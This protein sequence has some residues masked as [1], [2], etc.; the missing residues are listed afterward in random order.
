MK[1]FKMYKIIVKSLCLFILFTFF[2]FTLAT[3]HYVD[4]NAAG[5]NDGSSWQNAWN[6]LNSINWNQV[7]SGDVIY[8]STGVYYETLNIPGG[9]SGVTIRK[10]IDSGHNGT[11]V[12]DGQQSRGS[13]IIMDGSNNPI[14]SITLIGFEITG[15]TGSGIATNAESTGR[16]SNIT[17]DSLYVHDNMARGIYLNGYYNE[18]NNYNFVIKNSVFKAFAASGGGNTDGQTDLIFAGQVNN[19]LVDNNYFLQ[20]NYGPSHDDCFQGYLTSNVTL[21]NNIAIQDNDKTTETICFILEEGSGTHLFYNNVIYDITQN[22]CRD[23]KMFYKQNASGSAHTIFYGNTVYAHGGGLIDTGDPNADIQNNIFYCTGFASGYTT[24]M[25]FFNNG[26]GGGSTVDYNIYYDPTNTMNNVTGSMG[27]HDIE[28]N[29]LYKNIGNELNFDL[30]LQSGSPAIDAGVSLGYPYNTDKDGMSRPQGNGWDI[31][32]YEY[33]SGPDVTPPQLLNADILDS[34]TV[35]ANFSEALENSSA[36]NPNNYTISNGITVNSATLSGSQVTLQTTVHSNG[37]YTLTVNNVTDLS[38]NVISPSHNTADY[39]YYVEPPDSLMMLPIDTAYGDIQ[40]PL[41]TPEKTFD[42]KGSLD[43]DPDSRWAAQPMPEEITYDLGSPQ[44]IHKVKL[45]FYRYEA[46]RQY[47][48]SVSVSNDNVNWEEIVPYTMSSL[49]EWTTNSFAPVT[50][51]Y[52]KV[53]FYDNTE[54]DWAGL[55]EIQIWGIINEVTP[56]ELNTFTAFSNGNTVTLRWSTI[57]ETNNNYFEIQRSFDN[58]KFSTIGVVY[59]SGTTSN[60]HKYSYVDKNQEPVD[61]FYRLRQFDFNGN[62][63]VLNSIKVSISNQMYYELMQNYPNP[64]N[65]TTTIKFSLPKDEKVQMDIFNAL[66]QMVVKLVDKIYK[67]GIH[68]VIFMGDNL[69]SGVYFYKIQAG[70]YC[71]IRKMI[72]IK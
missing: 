49:E 7:N 54:S 48:Y 10:G 8:V 19:V 32:A 11:V 63:N 27:P 68:E 15:S 64:F 21:S 67:K 52:L 60:P 58:Q 71:K 43:G 17:M 55:W 25:V 39:V 22:N 50:R 47:H 12:I 66:G 14:D 72:L 6:S 3:N 28:A 53:H 38:G 61:R 26:R 2:S 4:K 20:N 9:T 42:G 44:E 62:Y 31:G 16:V 51:Q 13:C 70:S 59:G 30:S 29:P 23:A 1:N 34:N 65:P 46:G 40:E 37:N 69:P 18:A 33:Q 24:N 56:V 45:S 57:T 36:E 41:H 35:V 5:N